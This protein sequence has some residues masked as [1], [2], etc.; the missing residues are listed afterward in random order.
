MGDTLFGKKIILQP[1]S[2]IKSGYGLQTDGSNLYFNNVSVSLTNFTPNLQEVTDAGLTT[3]RTVFF[4]NSET[5]IVCQGLISCESDIRILTNDNNDSFKIAIGSSN[6]G[7][8]NQGVHSIAIGSD[9]GKASQ[10]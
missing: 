5:S 6:V 1:S 7:L 3:D 2:E 10:E 8:Q 9:S 4:S